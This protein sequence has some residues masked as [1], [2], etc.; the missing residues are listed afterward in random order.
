MA[1]GEHNVAPTG[2]RLATTFILTSP[3]AERQSIAL[4]IDGVYLNS[5]NAPI[6][7]R[8]YHVYPSNLRNFKIHG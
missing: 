3:I 4:P 6:T 7:H 2:K 8:H 5:K 1:A